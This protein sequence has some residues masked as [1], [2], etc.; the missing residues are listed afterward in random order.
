[1]YNV[2]AK[3]MAMA[4]DQF[5]KAALLPWEIMANKVEDRLNF[6]NDVLRTDKARELV[7]GWKAHYCLR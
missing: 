6:T 5:T 7:R 4:M 3:F 2:A 1:V